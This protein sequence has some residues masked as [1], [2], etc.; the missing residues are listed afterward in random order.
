MEQAVRLGLPRERLL[1]EAEI[2][3]LLDQA[4]ANGQPVQR[5]A[6]I[7]S[8]DAAVSIQVS[9]DKL[10]AT[11][12]IRKGKGAGRRLT[13]QDVSNAIRASGVRTFDVGVVKKDLTDFYAGQQED[14]VALWQK[15][16]PRHRAGCA[17][18]AVKF[19][20]PEEAQRAEQS[21]RQGAP[22]V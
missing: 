2:Q 22:G 10:K 3:R 11:L 7:P 6:L 16:G 5:L 15:A 13:L 4:A 14:E 1:P 18:V 19:A 9:P 20:R 12:S 8:A 21:C 17:W